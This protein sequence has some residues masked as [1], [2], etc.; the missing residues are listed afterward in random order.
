MKLQQATRYAIWATVHMA[1]R[2]GEQMSAADLAQTYGIS[3]H[4]LA[5]VLRT[6]A[7]AKIVTSTRGPGGGCSF[8]GDARRLT[9]FDIINLFENDWWSS[10]ADNGA[11]SVGQ[12]VSRV[13]GEID[14]I[15]MA[16]LRSV[17]VQTIVNNAAR[18][19]KKLKP[20]VEAANL[21]A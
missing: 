10:E 15:T 3:Q 18:R 8:I 2:P 9:L 17:T 12:E 5:K 11:T 16:T 19:E 4:H 6:L 7:F 20:A 1:S 21:S 14:R 13:L